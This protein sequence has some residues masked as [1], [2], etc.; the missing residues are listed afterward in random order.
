[1]RIASW[2]INSIR[3]REDLLLDWVRRVEPD[4]L[5]LQET[6]VVDDEFPTDE[7]MR[8][9]YA[10]AMSGQPSYNGVAILAKRPISAIRIGLA[11]EGP[12]A[13]RRAIA[14]TVGGVRVLNV[15][16][17]NGKSIE[18][19]SFV[20]KLRW[21]ERLRL[22]L[23]T[24]ESA[25]TPLV[26]CG[27]FNICRDDR[28]VYAPDLYRGQLHFHPDEQR[29]L[30]RVLDFG[31]V[32]TFRERHAEGARYSFWDYRAA[33]FRRNEGMRIDYVF[34]SRALLP[35][36]KDCDIDNE[37]RHADKPSD[38]TPVVADFTD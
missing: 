9:G 21:L 8:L 4:V 7:L 24:L 23:D 10:V 25:D 6:K 29:A 2:N 26:L 31:L 20:E 32:D 37:P 33:A 17:P 34:A 27:D 1:V 22:T 36:L 15:Y 11:G 19:P 5:C 28:D 18:S 38:H 3:V 30:N 14:A 12:T 16:V 35:R 13:E